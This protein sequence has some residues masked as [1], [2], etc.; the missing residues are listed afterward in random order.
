MP[1]T[2]GQRAGSALRT[3][4]HETIRTWVEERGGRPARVHGTGRGDDPGLLRIDYP[5]F[6]GEDTLEQISWDEWFRAFDEHKLAFLYGD[7]KDSR[8]SKLVNR[9]SDSDPGA[10][11]NR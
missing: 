5:G 7:E 6:S 1:S 8:F 3:T 2:H 10:R 9:D 11:H 4:D